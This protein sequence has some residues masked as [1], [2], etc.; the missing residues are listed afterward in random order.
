MRPSIVQVAFAALLLA[1]SAGAQTLDTSIE[2]KACVDIGFRKKTP[3]YGECV[4]ELLERRK[5]LQVKQ[6]S[7]ARQPVIEYRNTPARP[8]SR[9][10]WDL[11]SIAANTSAATFLNR[12]DQS[13]YQTVKAADVKRLVQITDKIGASAGI[14]PVLYVTESSQLNAASVFDNSG[15][16]IVFLYKPM[17]DLIVNDDGMAAALIGHEI[18]HLYFNHQSRSADAKAAGDV[19]GVIAGIA[20]EVL[21]QRKLGV[22]NLGVN[23]GQLLGVAVTTSFTRDQERE[24]DRQGII[25][26][27]MNGYDPMGAARLFQALEAKSGNS[28][29]PF[30][31][32]HPNPGER[33]E[34][35]RAIAQSLR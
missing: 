33:V 31:Q 34:N 17:Y 30:F 9:S 25:W 15:R 26:A 16:P 22:T 28:P 21:A 20:L 35:A 12:P 19:V 4:L 10:M 29:L 32:T 3:D 6:A 18:A 23:G 27:N 8:G 13:T 1:T 11:R 5:Q 2:E 7:A 14:Q 24:A